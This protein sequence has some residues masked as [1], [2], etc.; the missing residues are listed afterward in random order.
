MNHKDRPQGQPVPLDP[1]YR[2][3]AEEF[4]AMRRP[5]TV[6]L[7]RSQMLERR[8]L[9]G[10]SVPPDDQLSALVAIQRSAW[11]LERQLR[12]LQPEPSPNPG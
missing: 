12:A 4:D 7:A 3:S 2:V 8:V 6:I 1:G 10:T 5:L 9:Q 11:E